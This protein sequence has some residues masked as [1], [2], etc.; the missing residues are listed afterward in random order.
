MSRAQVDATQNRSDDYEKGGIS[1]GIPPI[2]TQVLIWD[3]AAAYSGRRVSIDDERV[4]M[5]NSITTPD[6]VVRQTIRLVSASRLFRTTVTTLGAITSVSAGATTTEAHGYASIS[7]FD[8]FYH[9]A[10]GGAEGV[11][12]T[13]SLHSGGDGGTVDTHGDA[14]A[15]SG[16]L[17]VSSYS[18]AGVGTDAQG[19]ASA[20]WA[21][22][23]PV[24]SGSI[25]SGQH[26]TFDVSVIVEGTLI[27]E[28]A[29]RSNSGFAISDNIVIGDFSIETNADGGHQSSEGRARLT[30]DSNGN[31]SNIGSQSFRLT[32]SDVPFIFGRDI[33]VTLSLATITGTTTYNLSSALAQANY[34]DTM[35]WGGL[36]DVRDANGMLVH[37]YTAISPNSGFDFARAAESSV[38]EPTSWTLLLAGVSLLTLV[39][40]KTRSR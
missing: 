30:V 37:D 8:P 36:S 11:S 6:Q 24:T 21:D 23:F 18:N 7:G 19:R 20:S 38:P 9:D 27:G 34:G 32:F 13:A 40:Y 16:A 35:I 26:G 25:A 14:S 15:R 3:G 22:S 5:R 17:H 31:I 1:K 2:A 29:A 10:Y 12:V 4:S 33:G 28:A 39:T